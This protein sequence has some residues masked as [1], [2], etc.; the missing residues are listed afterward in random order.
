MFKNYVTIA[1]RNILRHKMYSFINIGGLTIGLTACILIALFVQNEISY[2]RWLKDSERIF[3]LETTKQEAGK[4]AAR[5]AHSPG[6]IS[7]ALIEQFN[8][9]IEASTRMLRRQFYVARNELKLEETVNLVDQSFFDVLDLPI[10]EGNR[11]QLSD[12]F[13]SIVISE[14]AA[15]KYFGDQSPIGHTLELQNGDMLAKV[16]AVLKDLPSNT[17][18][19]VDFLLLLDEARFENQPRLLKWWTSSNVFTYVK[20]QSTAAAASLEAALPAF[21]DQHVPTSP[22]PGYARDLPAKEQVSISLMPLTDIHLHSK[23]RGQQKPPGDIMIVYSFSAIALLILIIAVINFAN[24]SSARS[25]LRAREVALRKT[26]GATR[27]QIIVQF[28]GETFLTTMLALFLALVMVE[29]LLPWFNDMIVKLLDIK[30]FADPVV[31]LGMVALVF[32]LTVGAGAQPAFSISSHKPAVILHSGGASSYKTLNGRAVLTT[33]QFMVSVSLMIV[34]AVIYSQIQYVK[35]MD[36][37]IN[38]T[39]K[40]TLYHMTYGETAAVA[41]VIQ[42]KIAALPEVSSTS[43]T[44]RSFP[45]RGKWSLPAKRPEMAD[46]HDGFRLEHVHGEHN[47]LE[48]FGARLLAGRFFSKDYQA[49]LL[50]PA[51][52]NGQEATQSGILNETAIAYLG[53]TSAKEALGKTVHI[54]QTDESFV[55]TTIVGVVADIQLRSAREAIDPMVFVVRQGPLWILNADIKPGSEERALASIDAIWAEMVPGLPLDRDF[56]EDQINQHYQPDEQRGTIF[57]YFSLLAIL[58][59]CLGL[60]GLA[61]FSAERRTREVGIRKILGAKVGNIISLLTLQFSKPVL[62]ANIVAWPLAWYFASA[63]LEGFVNRVDL[64]PYYFFGA[65]AVA[66]FIATATVAGHAFKTARANPISALRHE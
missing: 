32:V 22:G 6:P 4:P 48:F 9:T 55:S 19:N 46:T 52:P 11:S 16:V 57:A 65:G 25:F 62:L 51:S 42:R 39:G 37:G 43:F 40:L 59:S 33:L 12:N 14:K 31:Q 54:T 15:R 27:H 38:K 60:Y 18:L 45:I 26:V 10:I 34:T 35:T 29:I 41:N 64:S 30:S 3:R 21:L 61:A 63:W 5:S 1:V 36:I 53:F 8:G 50:Q 28:L 47:M 20:L 23:V 66:L 44:T 13:Q 17:H 49:D 7:A 24:L 58:V 2:D 56:I